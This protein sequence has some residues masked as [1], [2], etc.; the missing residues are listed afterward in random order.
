MSVD[1]T[2]SI[3]YAYIWVFIIPIIACII[4]FTLCVVKL[5]LY[6][7]SKE[8][9]KNYINVEQS[10]MPEKEKK[11]IKELRKTYLWSMMLVIIVIIIIALSVL[12]W[13]PLGKDIA[14]AI[15]KTY[16]EEDVYVM[17]DCKIQDAGRYTY[18]IPVK[19]LDENNSFYIHVRYVPTELK[20]GQIIRIQVL[21]N[22]KYGGYIVYE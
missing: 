7:K 10:C 14:Y 21:P 15:D 19:T 11:K 16:Q 13:I 4:L 22:S 12:T 20:A 18:S 6:I 17:K 3:I 5:I 2:P 1:A 8:K 9:L